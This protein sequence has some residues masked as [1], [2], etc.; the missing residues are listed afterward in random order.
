MQR[1]LEISGQDEIAQ[2]DARIVSPARPPLRPSYPRKSILVLLAIG[3]GTVIGAFIAFLTDRMERGFRQSR[4]VTGATGLRALGFIPLVRRPERAFAQL[5]EQPRS[6]FAEAVRAIRTSLLA[7]QEE[8]SGKI[9]LVTSSLQGEGKSLLAASLARSTAAAGGRTLLVDCDLRKPSVDKLMHDTAGPGLLDLLAGS[10]AFEGAVRSDAASG[11]DYVSC[12]NRNLVGS[13]QDVLGSL[14]MRN[15][16]NRARSRYDLVIL[17]APPI[18]A[19]SD[20]KILARYADCTVFVIR[21]RTTP[22]EVVRNALDL[23]EAEGG[24]IAGVVLSRVDVK[25][26]AK[27]GLH[28]SAAYHARYASYFG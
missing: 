28:D 25:K 24:P 7:S 23:F 19:V 6:G 22:R 9:L 26:Q 17:D 20:A 5:T 11:M 14:A 15:F 13:P 1:Q 3:S 10:V 21:W 27:L 18:L 12:W 8:G 4:D 16:I 2:P